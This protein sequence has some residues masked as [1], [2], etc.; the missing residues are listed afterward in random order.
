M[1]GSKEI[2]VAHIMKRDLGEDVEII[3]LFSVRSVEKIY[4][5]VL[6]KLVR[7]IVCK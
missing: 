3:I 4:F 2:D 1:L 6:S 5:F 7:K